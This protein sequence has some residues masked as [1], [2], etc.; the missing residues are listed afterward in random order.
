[1]KN[2]LLFCLAILLSGATIAQEI[3]HATLSGRQE[4]YAVATSGTGN[5]T[6]ELTGNTLVVSGLFSKMSSPYDAL[7]AGGAHIHTG[8]PGQTGDV[9]FLLASET[10]L[11]FLSGV[12][13]PAANTLP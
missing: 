8:L 7:V 4:V 10:D 6:A 12:F 9:T 1:M 3:F 13:R 5:I 2:L 11:D